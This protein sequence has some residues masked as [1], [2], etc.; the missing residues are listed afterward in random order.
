MADPA[1]ATAPAE[2]PALDFERPVI[3]LERKIEALVRASGGASEL[4]PQIA[5]LAVDAAS[6]VHA[7]VGEAARD[8][9]SALAA[10]GALWRA[11]IR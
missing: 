8:V 4:R 1:S 11:R 3:D 9:I 10:G 5:L 6:L 7:H 2:V